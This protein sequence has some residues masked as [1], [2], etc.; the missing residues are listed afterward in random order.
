M[1]QGKEAETLIDFIEKCMNQAASYWATRGVLEGVV[2][3]GSI[4]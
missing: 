3:N 2:K 1:P 4:L